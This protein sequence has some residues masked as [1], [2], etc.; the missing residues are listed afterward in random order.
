MFYF[1]VSTGSTWCLN[2]SKATTGTQDRRPGGRLEKRTGEWHDGD[3]VVFDDYTYTYP[4]VYVDFGTMSA[5]D[6]CGAVGGTYSTKL[7]FAPGELTT[8]EFRGEYVGPFDP[9]DMP[10]PN[11]SAWGKAGYY[12]YQPQINSTYQPFVHI[13]S[14]INN[15]DP[16]WRTCTVIYNQKFDPPQAL[17]KASALDPAV[18]A[19]NL[20]PIKSSA[21]P[22]QGPSPQPASTTYV[23]FRATE[24]SSAPEVNLPQPASP[25]RPTETLSQQGSNQQQPNTVGKPDSN[26]GD[27][28]PLLSQVVATMSSVVAAQSKAQEGNGPQA[29]NDQ[30]EPG[31]SQYHDDRQQTNQQHQ[32]KASVTAGLEPVN[33]QSAPSSQGPPNSKQQGSNQGDPQLGSNVQQVS[34]ARPALLVAGQTLTENSP[35]IVIGGTPVAYSAG[36]VQV[37][38]NA[39][40]AIPQQ[41][42][43]DQSARQQDQ[44]APAPSP[45]TVDRLTFI[46]VAS[47]NTPNQAAFSDAIDVGQARPALVVAGQTLT[48]NSPSIVVGGTPVAYSAGAVQVGTNAPVAIPQQQGQDQ[49]ARQQD[50]QAP[51]PSPITVD[52][53]TFVPVAST[54]SPNQAAFSDAIDIGGQPA[55]VNAAGDVEIAGQTLLP[56][57]SPI[58]VQEM[59]LSLGNGVLVYGSQTIPLNTPVLTP[60]ATIANQVINAPSSGQ[61]LVIQ[62]KTLI[63]NGAPITIS[64]TPIRLEKSFL[65]VGSSMIGF[66][67]QAPAPPATPIATVA[68]QVITSLPSPGSRL[69]IAGQTVTPNSAAVIIAGTPISIGSSVLVIGTRTIPLLNQPTITPPPQSIFTIGGHTFTANPTSFVIAPGT[70]ITPGIAISLSGTLI[71]LAAGGGELRVGTSTFSLS[72]AQNSV[73]TIGSQVFTANPTGFATS[74]QRLMPGQAVTI[75]GTRVALGASG[76]LVVGSQTLV[77]AQQ[78]GSGGEGGGGLGGLILSGL[79]S[80]GVASVTTAIGSGDSK[81][82]NGNGNGSLVLFTGGVEGLKQG[83][84]SWAMAA[85]ALMVTWVMMGFI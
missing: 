14:R 31:Q 59:P 16:A 22:A 79:G 82:G 17:V 32:N 34:K 27:S 47:T 56:E 42:G 85:I 37:G 66:S 23:P 43:Q 8:G 26:Q 71:S 78:T 2:Y 68:N 84:E 36:A 81:G 67:P 83:M 33:G 57:G 1:P 80:I 18:T 53:L 60:I 64:G 5:G 58:I 28:Q 12:G 50:Q 45:I 15:L 19:G 70:T 13:P 77:L 29:G 62:G 44:Q 65:I 54:N 24:P 49:S 52:R 35:S 72:P 55:S 69:I 30:P 75:D 61:V 46:P 7:A 10:C 20:D 73:F 40:V 9:K 41:Q 6:G 25:Q 39:P 63:P 4:S 48:E 74:G 38:T 76:T 51:A 3:I 21:V 11:F